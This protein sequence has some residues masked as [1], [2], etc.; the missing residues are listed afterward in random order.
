MEEC[1]TSKASFYVTISFSGGLRHGSKSF[2]IFMYSFQKH[3][4]VKDI[5]EGRYMVMK[6]K[7]KKLEK[8]NLKYLVTLLT[9]PSIVRKL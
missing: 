8:R 1:S 6:T 9:T 2:M 5:H 3:A 4:M 7:L